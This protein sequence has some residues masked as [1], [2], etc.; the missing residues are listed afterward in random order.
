VIPRENARE[1]EATPEGIE[2]VPVG[3]VVEALA[4]LGLRVPVPP[5]LRSRPR[6][7]LSR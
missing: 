3:T 7:R 5:A 4:A 2:V 1:I 6:T